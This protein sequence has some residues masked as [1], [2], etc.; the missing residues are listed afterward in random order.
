MKQIT[1]EMIRSWKPCYDPTYVDGVDEDWTGTVLDVLNSDI[2]HD[3][4][5]WLVL[6]EELLPE[7]LLREF[8]WWCALQVIDM[9]Q[10]PDIVKEYLETGNEELRDAAWAAARD[11]AWAAARYA[12]LA[13]ARDAARDAQTEK[14]IEMVEKLEVTNE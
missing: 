5:L 7:T 2:P 4:K 8:A 9:W 6:R 10:A 14:L 3:D 12:A 11:A 13:A 1:I